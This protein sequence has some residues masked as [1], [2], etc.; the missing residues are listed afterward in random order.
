MPTS[1]RAAVIS[2]AMARRH[3]GQPFL[4]M[5][6]LEGETLQHRIEGKPLKIEAMLELAIQMADALDAAHSKGIIH[7]DIKLTLLPYVIS[8]K[9]RCRLSDKSGITQLPPCSVSC[10]VDRHPTSYAR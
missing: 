3:E 1:P 7:R 4:A 5:Q 9:A 2:G 6:F 8:T 10:F